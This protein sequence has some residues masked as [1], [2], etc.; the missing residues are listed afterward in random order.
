[1]ANKPSLFQIWFMIH[2]PA[3]IFSLFW[4]IGWLLGALYMIVAATHPHSGFVRF[5]L[6]LPAAMILWM[7]LRNSEKV[8]L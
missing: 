5:I 1:L 6:L 2:G 7:V 8:R 4:N 3:A